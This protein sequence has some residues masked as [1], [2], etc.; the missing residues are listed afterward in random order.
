M[1]ASIGVRNSRRV[2]GVALA[3]FAGAALFAVLAYGAEDVTER[4]VMCA[5]LVVTLLASVRALQLGTWV[6]GSRVT[7]RGWTRSRTVDIREVSRFATVERRGRVFAAAILASGKVI[8]LPMLEQGI[9]FEARS[10]ES[11][12]GRHLRTLNELRLAQMYPG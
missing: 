9:L 1:S 4:W 5:F 11:Q 2:Y 8:P 12:W 6:S 3:L 10:A 7:V